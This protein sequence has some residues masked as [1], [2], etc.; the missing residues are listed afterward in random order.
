M[1]AQM[2]NVDADECKKA[3]NTML[4]L[5][6]WNDKQ[7]NVLHNSDKFHSEVCLFEDF[8]NIRKMKVLT[9]LTLIY[10]LCSFHII[11]MTSM[12][13]TFNNETQNIVK[14]IKHDSNI[15]QFEPIWIYYLLMKIYK[16]HKQSTVAE[17]ITIIIESNMHLFELL[18]KIK[19]NLD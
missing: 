19:K 1:F 13:T 8:F 15:K 2:N 11:L 5:L 17:D 10:L 6:S 14:F 18:M 3:W 4:S 9:M 12:R 16:L 7:K